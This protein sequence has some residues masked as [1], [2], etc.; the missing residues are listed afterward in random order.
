MADILL[1]GFT[2][3]F[4]TMVLI[5]IIGILVMNALIDKIKK[6][7]IRYINRKRYYIDL[8]RTKRAISSIFLREKYTL[9]NEREELV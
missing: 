3:L 9:Y 8:L 7:Y 6:M 4:G 5:F 1:F 2:M